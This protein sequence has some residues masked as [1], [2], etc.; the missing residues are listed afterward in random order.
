LSSI[1]CPIANAEE[2]LAAAGIAD[3]YTVVGG[4]FFVAVPTDRTRTCSRRSCTDECCV[5][6][7]EQCRQ[8]MPEHGKLLAAELVLLPGDVSKGL[9]LAPHL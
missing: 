3:R 6:I 1:Y 4:D 2:Q 7:P 9:D 5:A 8:A